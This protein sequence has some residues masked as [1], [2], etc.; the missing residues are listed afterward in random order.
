L[1][2]EADIKKETR[3]NRAVTKFM[4]GMEADFG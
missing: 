1:V 4:G 3:L 2:T